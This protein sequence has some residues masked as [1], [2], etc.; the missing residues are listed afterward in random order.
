VIDAQTKL[1][2]LLGHPVSHSL[3]PLFQNAA[4]QHLCLPVVYLA[5]DVLPEH[6]G[7]V[8]SAF[9]ILG[10]SGF[11][12]TI[13]HKEAVCSYLDELREEAALLSSVN[14]V[15]AQEGRLI[16]YNTDVYGFR[17]SLEEEK[18]EV[19][20]ETFLL[21]GTGGVA[22]ALLFVLAEKGV[23]KILLANRTRSRAEALSRWALQALGVCCEVLDWGT[24]EGGTEVP[25]GGI[26][27]ATSLGMAGEIPP[28][29]WESLAPQGVVVDVVYHREGT[30]LVREAKRRG[31]KS[32][33]GKR[34]L[35]H[36]GARSFTLFT[37]VEAPLLVMEEALSG[38]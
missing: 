10:V 20:G 6:L 28:I 8:V 30:P 7:E 35:L 31:F 21:L 1:L 29:P 11:N 34:M 15:V 24:L 32:F 12:V 26:I 23:R 18:V 25:V 38:R 22:K 9:R 37:G 2:A 13:P 19:R 14:T 36:Q 3:S 27:Q 16:G 33:D 4:L 5:F 17:K